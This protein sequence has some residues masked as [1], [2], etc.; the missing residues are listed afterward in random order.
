MNDIQYNLKLSSSPTLVTC[1]GVS[2]HVLLWS[3]GAS[4]TSAWTALHYS[5][6]CF[7]PYYYQIPGNPEETCLFAKGTHSF[8][9]LLSKSKDKVDSV[10]W[11]C[12]GQNW[13][14][15]LPRSQKES[16]DH[17]SLSPGLGPWLLCTAFGT[18]CE[19]Q[20]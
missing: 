14:M 16:E 8:F 10:F 13:R 1:S 6:C 3:T 9:I 17:S 7:F 11:L 18:L 5:T 19:W 4:Q 15:L 20:R 2:S 12:G